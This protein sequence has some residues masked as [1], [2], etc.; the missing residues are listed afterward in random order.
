MGAISLSGKGSTTV[1]AQ[2]LNPYAQKNELAITLK[3]QSAANAFVDRLDLILATAGGWVWSISN[4]AQ[5]G[6]EDTDVP[7]HVLDQGMLFKP[8]QSRT[9]VFNKDGPYSV[10]VFRLASGGAAEDWIQVPLVRAGYAVPPPIPATGPVFVGFWHRPM[11]IVDVWRSGQVVGWLTIGGMLFNGTYD[12]LT[13]KSVAVK[14]AV[15][16]KTLLEETKPPAFLD[17]YGISPSGPAKSN[18]D[19]SVLLATPV[20]PFVYGFDVSEVPGAFQK[21]ELTV[22]VTYAAPGA[23][24]QKATATV[25]LRRANAVTLRPP[26]KGWWFWGNCADAAF[27]DGH[28]WPHQYLAFDL[29]IRKD[30]VSHVP[31]ATP[32]NE[33]FYAY[34]QPTLAAAAGPVAQADDS[35]DENDGYK[36]LGTGTNFVLVQHDGGYSGYVHL[37]KGKDSVKAGDMVAAGEQ[38]GQVGNS[39]GSSEPHLHFA[40]VTEDET[41]RARIRPVKFLLL[42]DENKKPASATPGNGMYFAYKK[43]HKTKKWAPKHPKKPS[44]QKTASKKK[45][46]KRKK[47][48]KK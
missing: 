28:T 9:Y 1:S 14:V 5:E 41:G 31:A 36:Q 35:S 24:D 43:P 8:G 44:K 45:A 12:K 42:S 20:S 23:A 32:K 13:A 3:N 40:F 25:P 6:L 17:W 47:A 38:L 22:T 16:G 15:D 26:V 30:G 18:P 37:R 7:S 4:L 11:E 48:A 34:G 33:D 10:A 2:P 29:T 46:P 39:G 27:F 19:G 21:A